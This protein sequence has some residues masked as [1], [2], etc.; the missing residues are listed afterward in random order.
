VQTQVNE[1]TAR[2]GSPL[3]N[4]MLFLLPTSP[5]ICWKIKMHYRVHNNVQIVLILSQINPVHICAVCLRSVLRLSSHLCIGLI[6]RL[7]T[8]MFIHQHPDIFPFSSMRATCFADL[9]IL[10]FTTLLIFVGSTNYDEDRGGTVVKVL[11][12]KSEGRWFDSS[13]CHWNFPLT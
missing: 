12:Y 10:D 13:W 6:N 2:S 3:K 7:I 8:F 4:L 11:C 1:P 9:I 5:H